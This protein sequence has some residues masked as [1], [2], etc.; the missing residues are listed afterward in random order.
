V[1]RATVPAIV[2]MLG[3]GCEGPMA[4]LA[5]RSPESQTVASLTWGIL[6]AGAVLYCVVLVALA[7]VVLRSRGGV[8]RDDA[9]DERAGQGDAGDRLAL[10]VAIVTSAGVVALVG[11]MVW[12]MVR[13]AAPGPPSLTIEVV[14]RRWWWEVRYPAHGVV[15]ANEIHVPG[16]ADVELWLTADD[17]IHSF[18]VPALHGKRDLI[19]G[20]VTR[21]RF[22]AAA[23]VHRG[24]CAEYCG[25]QHTGMGL[26]VVAEPHE[27]FAA[28]IARERAPASS[29]PAE[30]TRRAGEGVF[31]TWCVACHT[32]RGTPA[33]GR[34]GPD[35]TH[36]ASRRT[37]AA[38]VVPNAEA[39]LAAWIADPQ[40]LKPG[41]LMPTL[42]LDPAAVRALAAYLGGLK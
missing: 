16:G 7:L 10:W 36:V 37:L 25:V 40:A 30:E 23:G 11:A 12:T 38:G 18:W 5:P 14:G 2:A 39:T 17:V 27:A 24:Q 6:G 15:T 8:V 34:I 28:W 42:P 4:V 3:L 35:L 22:R 29:P 33:V 9:S 1:S 26:R 13:L 19:P 31:L 32:V 20:R 41:T 21:L